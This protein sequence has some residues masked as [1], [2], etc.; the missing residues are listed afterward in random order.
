MFQKLTHGYVDSNRAMD[1]TSLPK[2]VTGR[3]PEN[4][5]SSI[6]GM[7]WKRIAMIRSNRWKTRSRHLEDKKDVIIYRSRSN[8]H[9]SNESGCPLS[10]SKI[11]PSIIRRL[12]WWKGIPA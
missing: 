7:K 3:R 11:S 5:Q 8:S 4:L 1:L 9:L 12:F 10:I 6:I 2:I